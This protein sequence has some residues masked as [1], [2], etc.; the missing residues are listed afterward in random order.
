M[1]RRGKRGRS[2]RRNTSSAAVNEDDLS[3]A[4][5]SFVVHRGKVG[6]AVQVH[7]SKY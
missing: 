1:G 3:K 4:P 2:V 7:N 6:K 5:H